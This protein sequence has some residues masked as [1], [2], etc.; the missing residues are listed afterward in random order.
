MDQLINTIFNVTYRQIYFFYRNFNSMFFYRLIILYT[1]LVSN[2]YSIDEAELISKIQF[3]HLKQVSQDDG[4]SENTVNK[5]FQD[6]QG[7]IWLATELGIN[8]YDGHRIKYLIGEQSTL[9]DKAI[10]NINQDSLNNFWIATENGLSIFDKHLNE[11]Q[12]SKFPSPA[13]QQKNAN[14][15]IGSIEILDESHLK[16]TSWVVT[17][18]GLYR[19][20]IKNREINQ[21]QSMTL[22]QKSQFNLLSY[23]TDE[24]RIWLGTSQG[25]YFFELDSQKLTKL[26]TNSKIDNLPV[27]QLRQLDNDKIFLTNEEGFYQLNTQD[28]EETPKLS[29]AQIDIQFN[30][31]SSNLITDFI[32]SKNMDKREIIYS[33]EDSLFIFELETKKVVKLFSLSDVLPNT[34]TYRIRTLFLDSNDLLWIGTRNQGVYNWDIKSLDF[35]VFNSQSPDKNY[36]INNNEVWSIDQ[37]INGNYWIG[38]NKGL[39]YIDSSS[40]KVNSPYDFTNPEIS[41]KQAKIFDTLEYNTS[42][43][44]ATADDLSHLNTKTKRLKHFRPK[45]LKSDEKFIVFSL[46]SITNDVLWLGTNI[47]TLKFDTQ[48]HQFSYEK[49]LL[50]RNNKKMTRYITQVNEHI[51]TASETGV[52][53]YAQKNGLIKSL[54]PSKHNAKGELYSLTDVLYHNNKLWLSY[55]G[56]GIYIIENNEVNTLFSEEQSSKLAFNQNKITHLDKTNGF[57]DNSVYSLEM[58]HGFIWA[59]SNTGLIRINPEELNYSIYDSSIGLPNN[60]FNEGASLLANGHLLYGGSKGLTIINPT[61]LASLNQTLKTPRIIEIKLTQNGKIEILTF[62]VKQLPR[63]T[64]SQ[65]ALLSI[66]M[67]VLNFRKSN[68]WEFEYWFEGDKSGLRQKTKKPEITLSN[69]HLGSY[70]LNIKAR[71][72]YYLNESNS[73]QL[74]LIVKDGLTPNRKINIAILAI[75]LGFFLLFIIYLLQKNKKDKQ[76]LQLLVEDENRLKNALL[77]TNR[78]IWELEHSPNT[79]A[80]LTVFQD[81]HTPMKLSLERYFDYIHKDDVE[82]IKKI[83]LDFLKGKEPIISETYRVCFHGELIWNYIHGKIINFSSDNTPLKSSGIWVNVDK[84]K[85]I[86]ERLNSFSHAFESTLDIVFILDEHLT[87]IAVNKAYEISTGYICEQMIG[88]SMVDIAFSRFTAM[89]TNAIKKKVIQNKRWKGESSVPRRNASSF[90]VDIRIN[91]ITK[92]G[93]DNGYVVV[94]SEINES[95]TTRSEDFGNRFYDQ[96]TGLPNKVLAFDRLRETINRSEKNHTSFSL[97]LLEIEHIKQLKKQLKDNSLADLFGLFSARLL[98][99]IER[100]DTLARFDE[101][102]FIII[103]QH[104]LGD[105][106]TISTINQLIAETLKPFQLNNIDYHISVQAGISKYPDDSTNWAELVTKAQLALEKTTQQNNTQFSYFQESRNKR[107]IDRNELESKLSLAIENNELF[108]VFQPIIDIKKHIM[109]DAEV[110]FRWQKKKEQT[111]YPAQ[112]I[113]IAAEIGMLTKITD[114]M[115]SNTM[116][117]L[118]RW[119]QEDLH[120]T[121]NLNLSTKYLLSNSSLEFISKSLIDNDINPADIV[122]SLNED[123]ILVNYTK[124]QEII[125]RLKDLGVSLMLSEFGKD[126]APIQKIKNYDFSAIRFDKALIRRIGKDPFSELMIESLS[127]MI[128]QLE[129]TCMASGIENENQEA[130]LLK[131]DCQFGQGFLYSDPLTENQMRQLMLRV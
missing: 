45:W 100:E 107:A 1:C 37:D 57:A 35:K 94:M 74:K 38:S 53:I 75:F 54:L 67:T 44:L 103:M 56:D 34:A 117:S 51:I 48:T 19:Y 70:T 3:A 86:E 123:S 42:L 88:C 50:L 79:K 72:K 126:N 119:N 12:M 109:L 73:I 29:M 58:S 104:K 36:Q 118:S 114:W 68:S 10:T 92:D 30:K 110:S 25:V 78:G 128:N 99:Y 91:L 63:I 85:K 97:I 22:F 13:R 7:F 125:T 120:L 24:S 17:W 28:I 112:I 55:N 64:L 121:L 81:S 111:I 69:L 31:I 98:P 116:A 41:E 33:T 15:I 95:K 32:F 106:E 129:I 23:H 5:I 20:N 84:E 90:P 82:K 122:I 83:W 43:W 115:I 71:S 89:E 49:A 6:N 14:R 62:P 27:Y 40:L 4:L 105:G 101:T 8:R 65:N 61:I 21:P 108:L 102:H 2:A 26:V 11:I 93:R 76:R 16:G 60:E 52:L 39:N 113:P 59:S 127:K 18:N 47:G 124:L 131:H 96:V 9:P 46:T 80:E 77:D 87:V 66:K 130:F